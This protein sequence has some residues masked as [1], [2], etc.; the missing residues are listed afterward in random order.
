MGTWVLVTGLVVQLHNTTRQSEGSAS[1][2]GDQ[3]PPSAASGNP[4]R[5][6]D[7]AKAVRGF[8]VLSVALASQAL[9]L[10]AILLDDLSSEIKEVN[11]LAVDQQS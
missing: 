6:V 10:M 2:A 3:P 4:P 8:G 9:T 7:V 1:A 5:H 11:W